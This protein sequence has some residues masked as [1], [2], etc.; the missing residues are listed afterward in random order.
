MKLDHTCQSTSKARWLSSTYTIAFTPRQYRSHI[1]RN[2][3]WPPKSQL[4]HVSKDKVPGSRVKR[5]GRR[6]PTKPGGAYH[7]NVTWPFWTR[8]MLKPT[9]G[10]EL[11]AGQYRYGVAIWIWISANRASV[12]HTRW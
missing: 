10:M 2:L 4:Q 3:G 7:F 11:C 9:V 6:G 8:F 1:D 5:P 12:A